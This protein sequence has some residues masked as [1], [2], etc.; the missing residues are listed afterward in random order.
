MFYNLSFGAVL[1]SLRNSK[2]SGRTLFFI[3]IVV[4]IL[5][6]REIRTSYIIVLQNKPDKWICVICYSSMSYIFLHN[7]KNIE[8]PGKANFVY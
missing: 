2:T 3:F 4:K 1:E 6:Y 8:I 7:S 5:N